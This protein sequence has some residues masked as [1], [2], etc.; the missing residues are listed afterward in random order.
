LLVVLAVVELPL[1]VVQ[2]A[3]VVLVDLEPHQVLPFHQV[4]QL[5]LQSV[6]VVLV[7]HQMELAVVTDPHLLFQL[8][9]LPV[10]VAVA[11]T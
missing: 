8:S 1:T 7:V 10:A 5:Q 4:Q 3:V 2:R 9:M 6:L 11:V